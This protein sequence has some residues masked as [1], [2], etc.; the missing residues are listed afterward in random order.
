MWKFCPIGWNSSEILEQ[1]P[2]VAMCEHTVVFFVA[3]AVRVRQGV[4]TH[5][6]SC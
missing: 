6:S 2:S 3:R 1:H 4:T 5:V